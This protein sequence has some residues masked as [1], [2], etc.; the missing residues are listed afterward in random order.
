MAV[1]VH[2]IGFHPSLILEGIK[3]IMGR[4]PVERIYVLFDGKTDRADRYKVV[5]QRNAAKLAKELAFFKPIKL[6]VNPLSYTSVFSRLYSILY[7]ELKVRGG[8]ERGAR[9]FIDVTDMPPLMAAA[10]GAVA[11]MFKGVEVYGVVPDVRGD[12]IPNPRTPEFDDWLEHKDSAHAQAVVRLALPRRRAQAA[13]DSDRKLRVLLTLHQLNGSAES[14]IDLIKACGDDPERNPA[15][16]AAYSRLLKEMEEEGLV[17]REYGGRSRRVKL[18]EFGRA[19]VRALVR[20][21]EMAQRLA[22]G[23]SLSGFVTPA[24][25]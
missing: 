19:F 11:M 17:E 13:L 5:S 23:L 4:E 2:Y 9:V 24:R 21:E 20:G 8:G 6:P 10:A 18:T 22:P 16:K 12:F 25:P 15:V 14:V 3:G 7:Y 1:T